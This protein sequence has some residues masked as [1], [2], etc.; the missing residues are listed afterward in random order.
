MILK[1]GI[2]NMG[3]LLSIKLMRINLSS[4]KISASLSSMITYYFQS[5]ILSASHSLLISCRARSFAANHEEYSIS[6]RARSFAANHEEY[7]ISCRARSLAANHEEYS[8]A[9]R[10]LEGQK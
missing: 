9:Q 2:I 4:H 1:M 5:V 6:C 7:S 10:S 3:K 8:K